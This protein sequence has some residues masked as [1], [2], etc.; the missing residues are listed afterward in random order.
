MESCGASSKVDLR[1]AFL[2]LAAV[3]VCGSAYGALPWEGRGIESEPYLVDGA[4]DLQAIGAKRGYWD[5]HFKLTADIDLSGFTGEEFKIIGYYHSGDDNRA[6]TGGFDGDGHTIRNFSYESAGT[7]GIALFGYLGGGGAV[8]NLALEGVDL[9]GG[10]GNRVAALVAVNE[11][12][13]SACC[14]S[15]SVRGGDW[16][17]G[18]VGVNQGGTVSNC[19]ARCRVSGRFEVAGL[20]GGNGGQIS[21]CYAAGSVAG[22]DRGGLVALNDGGMIRDCF[23][24]R[25]SSGVSDMC[26][27]RGGSG[28]DN[29]NGKTTAQMHASSTFIGAGWDFVGE[30]SNGTA[31]I[32]K[33]TCDGQSYP[34][35][36]WWVPGPGDLGCPDGVDF[37][38]YAVFAE[39]WGQMGCG[40]CGGSDLTG[41][42]NVGF[43]DLAE[44]ADN[45]LRGF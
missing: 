27:Y 42:G 30:R 33:I 25:Q 14:A 45:W 26:S 6:F 16:V 3:L 1:Y 13:I 37:L 9:D 17:G 23:W 31:D 7:N 11:G 29:S 5:S 39:K 21:N 19:Y 40:G 35:L 18:L 10:Q 32:W 41:D 36:W 2:V 24:D 8:R 15:G 22:E 44:F 4:N 38:D 28:C 20:A 12:L 34:K 43:D